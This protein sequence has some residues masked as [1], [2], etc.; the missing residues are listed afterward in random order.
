[1]T[2]KIFPFVLILLSSL[3][4]FS[5][6]SNGNKESNALATDVVSASDEAAAGLG[7][8]SVNSPLRKIIHTADISCRVNDVL[9]VSL[10]LE[11]ATKNLQ[12]IVSESTLS[13]QQI[14]T[15]ELPFSADSLKEITSYQTSA[16][17]RLRVP[18]MY[19]DSLINILPSLAI[20][21]DS[22]KLLQ[23]DATLSYLS[24]TLKTNAG[25]KLEQKAETGAKKTK[26][27]L[28]IADR[29]E[30]TIDHQIERLQIN[31]D[32]AFATITINLNQPIQTKTAT[33]V[34]AEAAFKTPLGNSIGNA[35]R[36]GTSLFQN[37]LVGFVTLWPFWVLLILFLGGRNFYFKNRRVQLN[38]VGK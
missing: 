30:K 27:F 13:N 1:M 11:N 14:N 29:N 16:Y 3:L 7:L 22:R 4:L 20:F 28:S 19:K 8:D 23:T 24:N 2:K 17:L 34:N 26:E 33:I 5:C 37:L 32:V 15:K 25:S 36:N 10:L 12:G 6:N 38:N 9:K 35:L 31:D 18:A 21:V